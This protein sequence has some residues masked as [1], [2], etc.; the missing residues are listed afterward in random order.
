MTFTWNRSKLPQ[1]QD[2]AALLPASTP[3]PAAAAAPVD[4]PRWQQVGNLIIGLYDYLRTNVDA[5]PALAAVIPT[6]S[7][8]VADY[9]SRQSAD[10]FDPVRTVLAA[11]QQ[12]RARD[13]SIPEP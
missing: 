1:D 11:V 9:R 3:A 8:A 4:D 10:P 6:L 12:Q 13:S 2:R 7:S 5:H